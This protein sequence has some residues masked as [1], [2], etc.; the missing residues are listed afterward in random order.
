MAVSY[1]GNVFKYNPDEG[2]RADDT[3]IK[4]GEGKKA[5]RMG[6]DGMIWGHEHEPRVRAVAQE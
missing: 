1:S 4:R 2:M 6:W 5:R 3:V